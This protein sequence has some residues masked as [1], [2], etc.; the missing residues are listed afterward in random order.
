[1]AS[2]LSILSNFQQ[3]IGQPEP[4]LE[5]L[6]RALH[7]FER[8]SEIYPGV[9]QYQNKLAITYMMISNLERQQGE[10]ADALAFARKT[11]THF[12]RLVAENSKDNVYRRELI[13]SCNSLGRSLVQ[14]G[15]MVEAVRSFQHAIDLAE[16]TAR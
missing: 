10:K 5:N 13:K 6:R 16:L 1:M 15:E 14:V 2:E 9:A 12:E 7:Y 8:I 3:K 11:R 4:A